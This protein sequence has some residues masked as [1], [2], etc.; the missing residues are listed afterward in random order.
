MLLLILT[1][2]QSAEKKQ[3]L[4]KLYKESGKTLITEFYL[5]VFWV[6]GLLGSHSKGRSVFEGLQQ[7]LM[8]REIE[9]I[10]HEVEVRNEGQEG[11]GLGG[12]E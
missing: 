11:K 12:E 8:R 4:K 6:P 9:V 1:T 10:L 2:D 3:H 7:V 5:D